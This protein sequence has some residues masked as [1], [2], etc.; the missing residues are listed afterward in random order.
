M[1]EWVA[2]QTNGA[3]SDAVASTI[4]V[5]HRDDAS[6]MKIIFP[7]DQLKEGEWSFCPPKPGGDPENN[8]IYSADMGV[9][10]VAGIKIDQERVL[11]VTNTRKNNPK[12]PMKAAVF[13]A[14][15]KDQL[16]W[17]DAAT[18][19]LL[20]ASDFFEPITLGSLVTPGL[21]LVTQ[22]F[23]TKTNWRTNR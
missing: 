17:R 15:Y 13:R 6:R 1:G 3:G 14:N 23:D 19:R 11:V 16:T 21:K 9:G 4:V 7:F 5:A 22:P 10:K 8:M 12:Q 2:I 18:G 20:A